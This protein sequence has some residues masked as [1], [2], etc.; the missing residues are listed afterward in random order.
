VS[1]TTIND[2][3]R[4]VLTSRVYDVAS[5]TP[6]E[7]AEKLSHTLGTNVYLKREDMQPVH[8]FKLRGAYNKMCRLTEAEK[9]QG[10]IAASAGNHAQGVALA[11][12]KLGISALIVMP[13]TTPSIKVDAVRGYGAE[14]VLTGDNYSEAAEACAELTHKTGRTFIHP[15]DDPLVIAGQGNNW[16]RN[17]RTA[18]RRNPYICAHRRRRAHSRHSA[19]CKGGAARRADRGR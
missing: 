10:V 11:A 5:K 6:L 18:A 8:S 2:I 14:V 13:R 4:E 12:Q 9:K 19:L 3:V 15:F 17:Y 16:P 1:P 7:R